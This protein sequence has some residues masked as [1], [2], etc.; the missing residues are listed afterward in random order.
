M[1]SPVVELAAAAASGNSDLMSIVLRNLPAQEQAEMAAMAARSGLRPD[2]TA[3]LY[4]GATIW[5]HKDTEFVQRSLHD[6]QALLRDMERNLQKA[7]IEALGSEIG[8]MLQRQSER[9]L[10]E[11]DKALGRHIHNVADKAGSLL[12]SKIGVSIVAAF[13]V[14]AL[15]CAIGGIILGEHIREMTPCGYVHWQKSKII[16]VCRAPEPSHQPV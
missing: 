15:G 1:T 10:T 9:S 11:F 6:S 14:I 12:F 3:W 7:A 2:D 16:Y 5:T 8:K 4:I 13:M